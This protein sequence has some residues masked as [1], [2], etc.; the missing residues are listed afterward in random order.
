MSARDMKSGE[1]KALS[2]E[3]QKAQNPQ[4]STS[5]PLGAW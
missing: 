2:V 1:D 5:F 3:V 4:V